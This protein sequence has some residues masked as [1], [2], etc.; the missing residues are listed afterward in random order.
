MADEEQTG[1]LGRLVLRTYIVRIFVSRLCVR[2]LL[3]LWREGVCSQNIKTKLCVTSVAVKGMKTEAKLSMLTT[4]KKSATN[5]FYLFLILTF[6]Y[7]FNKR[8]FMVYI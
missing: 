2:L 4:V 1:E 8:L 7:L 5:S 6:I 3:L